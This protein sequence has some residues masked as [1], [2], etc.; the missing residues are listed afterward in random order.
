L[1]DASS[2]ILS[3]VIYIPIILF[4][5]ICHHFSYLNMFSTGLRSVESSFHFKPMGGGRGLI[6]IDFMFSDI[7][8]DISSFRVY[9]YA[10]HAG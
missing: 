8:L 6:R 10:V 5:L 1:L 7:V 2:S 9:S 3:S 4:A